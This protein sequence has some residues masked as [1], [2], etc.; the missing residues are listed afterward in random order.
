M[1][2]DEVLHMMDSVQEEQATLTSKH[3]P[4]TEFTSPSGPP[5]VVHCSAGIGRSGTFCSIHSLLHQYHAT[6]MVSVQGTVRK[7][8]R[9][10]AYSIQAPE[11]YFF[12]YAS[13]L[14]HM[15][16]NPAGHADIPL[17][18]MSVDAGATD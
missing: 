7:L 13:I 2:G 8:R 3:F 17:P 6:G 1:N 5:I 11:Q 12:I 9:Q 10:R 16:K 14:E 18:Q 15:E 4:D